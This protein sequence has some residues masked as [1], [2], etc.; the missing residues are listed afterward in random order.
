[1]KTIHRPFSLQ[2][3]YCTRGSIYKNCDIRTEMCSSP[4]CEFFPVS[5]SPLFTSNGCLQMSDILPLCVCRVRSSNIG[6]LI[7][8]I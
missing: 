5:G 1:M 4:G 3:G 2:R 7:D 8:N 6:I